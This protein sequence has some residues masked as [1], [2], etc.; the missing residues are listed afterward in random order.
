M[1]KSIFKGVILSA[2][3][4]SL[5]LVGQAQIQIPIASPEASVYTKV[6]LTDIKVDYFRPKVK[7]R[8]IFGPTDQFM[9]QYGKIWR[10][11]A[12]S[13]TVIHFSDPVKVEGKEVAA[14][15]YLIFSIP[16]A[17]EWTMMLYSD[18]SI[19]GNAAA[20]DTSKEVVRFTVKPKKLGEQ[21]ETFT[22]NISDISEDNTRANIEIT[23]ADVSLKF[24][25]EVSFDE[26]V[27]KA[28]EANTKV[29]PAN[30]LT[31]ARYYYENGKDLKQAL[32]WVDM[33][34]SVNDK[35]FW[36]VHLKAQIQKAMG[37]KKGARETAQKSLDMAKSAPNDF[38]YIKLNEDLIKSLK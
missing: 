16:N 2:I 23:W 13:G 15:K 7:G 18:L 20:Y 21:V 1:K 12:N 5:A 25:V 11:G 22:V 38:G 29:N 36:N 9:E 27:L 32:A 3:A 26:R 24:G 6:G 30:Y 31:A 34:L 33:Y 8:K 35:Q 17:T 4:L 19:G 28:I 10:T 37:D 14:G